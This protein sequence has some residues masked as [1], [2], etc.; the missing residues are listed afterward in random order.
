[1]IFQ[2]FLEST[3]FLKIG[4][5][6]ARFCGLVWLSA[7]NC[8]FCAILENMHFPSEAALPVTFHSPQPTNVAKVMSGKIP[9]L[10]T[11]KHN[12]TWIFLKENH[13]FSIIGVLVQGHKNPRK[14]INWRLETN[15]QIIGKLL[16]LNWK[17]MKHR[18]KYYLW[19][20]IE[21]K[22]ST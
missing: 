2:G 14:T 4:H 21:F 6:F 20:K 10:P 13:Y 5:V 15:I 17:S 7:S 8:L 16:F 12:S 1:M 19:P 22:G 9:N 18:A 3:F 11:R